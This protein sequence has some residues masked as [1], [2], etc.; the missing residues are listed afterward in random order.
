MYSNKAFISSDLMPI[1]LQAMELCRSKKPHEALYLM[2]SIRDVEIPDSCLQPASKLA[3]VLSD[4]LPSFPTI[5]IIFGSYSTIDSLV[6]NLRWHLLLN[7]WRLSSSILPIGTW[8][9]EV[10]NPDSI[11]YN[12]ESD[13]IWLFPNENL[14]SPAFTSPLDG[15][16][17][18]KKVKELI[19]SLVSPI[20]SLLD[21]CK[22]QLIVA[23]Y[24]QPAWRIF[25]NLE[26]R[27]IGSV[28]WILN[29][30]NEKLSEVLLSN[31]TLF[32]INHLASA[33]GLVG[34]HDE[35]LKA[36][37]KHPFS[38]AAHSFVAR[39]MAGLLLGILGRS[40]KCVILDLDNTLWGGVIGDDGLNGI[41]IGPNGGAAG[42]SFHNFQSWL[43]A[44]SKRGIILAVCSK[45]NEDIAKRPFIELTSM[46]LRLD[47]IAAFSANWENKADNIRNLA[48]TLNL[49][50]DSFIFIDDN[51]AERALVR[52]ELPEV[53][54]PELSR[55][56]S[57]YIQDLSCGRYFE[58][59]GLSS[60]DLIRS[61][62]YQ[63]NSKLDKEISQSSDLPSYLLGLEM[64]SNW[65]VVDDKTLP[66]ATQL[67][68]KTNQFQ[69]TGKRYSE[70]ELRRLL[71]DP[72]FWVGHFSLSD[73][74]GEHGITSVVVLEFRGEKV[75]IDTWVMSCRVFS[76]SFE[77]FIF[78]ILVDIV[79]QKGA[80]FLHGVYRPTNKNAVISSLLDD[81]GGV[82]DAHSKDEGGLSRIF[83]INNKEIY[84]TTY[85]K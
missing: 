62:A 33:Y 30:V 28:G 6:G 84:A 66:R 5:S 73:K 45:N 23:N 21:K 22:S 56:P 65:G 4:L 61:R 35:K 48:K 31:V 46:V 38:L 20:S 59:L 50:L 69:L 19:D 2:R 11:L 43:L 58:L 41:L 15:N 75:H 9:L 13:L 68:N 40:K 85:I 80:N 57:Q 18:D 36:H 37:S 25:G 53:L 27:T 17:A 67:I 60:E 8:H 52:S 83:N 74:Y 10:K 47:D 82:P 54:V 3:S 26:N 70:P 71:E 7:G 55:D 79:K 24:V 72:N 63:I 1:I 49:G 76:R 42:E 16:L 12:Q 81:L 14:I 39:S 51:P 29:R 78:N 44:L 32:D 64:R 77:N 34:W